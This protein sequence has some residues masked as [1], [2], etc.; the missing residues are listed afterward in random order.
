VVR[1][2]LEDTGGDVGNLPPLRLGLGAAATLIAGV[3]ALA[4][5]NPAIPVFALGLAVAVAR[6]HRPH[7]DPR[8]LT[9]LFTLTVTLGTISRLWQTP[10]GLLDGRSP[11]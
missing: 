9:L 1:Y 4:L 5:A 6:R 11:W 3:L 8:A 2:R 7:V 10:A